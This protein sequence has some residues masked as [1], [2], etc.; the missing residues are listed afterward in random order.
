MIGPHLGKRKYVVEK[1]TT[2]CKSKQT[3][4]ATVR[5]HLRNASQLHDSPYFSLVTSFKNR[6]INRDLLALC[7]L[8]KC[9][10]KKYKRRGK[11]TTTSHT[12][13]FSSSL[14]SKILVIKDFTSDTAKGILPPVSILIS[15]FAAGVSSTPVAT[16]KHGLLP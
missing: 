6:K 7:K 5:N 1:I 11:L 14:S 2:K 3:S 9:R 16:G 13:M 10:R 12:Q 8:R 4:I 15:I